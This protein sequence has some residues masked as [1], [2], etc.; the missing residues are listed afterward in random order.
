M[1]NHSTKGSIPRILPTV[2]TLLLLCSGVFAQPTPPGSTNNGSGGTNYY[3]YTPPPYV[4]GLKLSVPPLTGTNL[5]LNLLEA[6][7]AGKYDIYFASNLVSASWSD[8]VQGT[9]G[10]TNFILSFPQPDMGFFKTARTDPPITNAANMTISFPNLFVNT[11]L[12]MASV[13]GGPAA[14]MAVLVND[15]NIADAT[16]IPFS[17]VPLVLLGTNDGTYQIWFGFCGSDGTSYWSEVSV[18][19]DTTPPAVVITNPTASIT[20]KPMIQLQGYSPEPLTSLTFTVTNSQGTNSPGEGFVTDQYFDTNLFELTTNWFECLDIGLTQGTN[21]VSLRATDRAGNVTITNLIYIFDTNGDTTPPA[22]TLFWP[23][24][25]TQISGT[26]FTLRGLLDDETASLTAQIVST[27]GTTNTVNGLVE[28]DGKFWVENLPLVGGTNLITI[29]ATDAAGNT[30]VTNI[31]VFP[32]PVALTIDP[33]SPDQLWNQTLTVTGTID[34]SDYTVWANGAEASLNGDGTWT[35]TNVYLPPGGTAVIQARAI[36]NSNNGGNGTGG[37]GGG[38]V[39]YDNLGNPDPPQDADSEFQTNRPPY[40][41]VQSYHFS[42]NGSVNY[43]EFARWLPVTEDVSMN[44]ENGNGG[45]QVYDVLLNVFGI[46]NTVYYDYQTVWPADVWPPTLDGTQTVTGNGTNIVTTVGPPALSWESSKRQDTSL[47]FNEGDESNRSVSW[48]RSAKMVV[49]YFTGGKNTALR[50]N[51]HQLNVSVNEQNYDWFFW[52]Y[53]GGTVSSGDAITNGVT[54]GAFGEVIN[55]VAYAIL[56]DGKNVDVTPAASG[57]QNYNFDVSNP[58]KYF[59]YFEVFVNMPYPP[60]TYTNGIPV[61][62]EIN[63][64]WGHVWWRLSTDAPGDAVNKF[65]TTDRSQFLN[66][67]VGYCNSNAP[68]RFGPGYLRVPDGGTK[69]VSRKRY[70]GFDDLINGLGYTKELQDHPGTYDYR[71]NNCVTQTRVVGSIVGV[72]LPSS[73][74]PEYFGQ[75]LNTTPDVLQ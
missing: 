58:Q 52:G 28:R 7:P 65:M 68:S 50:N 1:K 32:S 23:Q 38:P 15:T 17:S 39:T 34:S 46:N 60:G 6:D 12:I 3:Y 18:T 5:S 56:P 64:D 40:V 71:F 21:Y 59:S 24:D 13:S 41:Y 45:R 70:I 35:A 47:F 22:I 9:N 43:Y 62:P 37:S 10:Q 48:T 51:L 69:S 67:E 54:A 74:I 30:S 61:P 42:Y 4:P 75:E 66:V 44:W 63:G 73:N 26:N 31:S 25:G 36:P 20:S 49:K 33:P 57:V 27:N 55:G 19:L 72:S 53:G 2:F 8:I 16:W 14:A 11:N 29:T